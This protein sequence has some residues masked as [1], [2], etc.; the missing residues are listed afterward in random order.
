MPAQLSSYIG[1]LMWLNPRT[2]RSSYHRLHS[3]KSS[4]YQAFTPS[5]LRT[6]KS[7]YHQVSIPPLKANMPEKTVLITGC[8]TG[9]LGAAMAKAYHSR[10]FRVFATLRNKSKAGS[11]DGMQGIEILELDVTSEESVRHCAK[12]V[13]KLTGGSLDVLVNNAGIS[14]IMPLLDTSVDEAKKMY[15]SN[16]WAVI[17]MTQAFA[18]MLI[19]SKGTICNISS[20]SSELVFAWQGIYSS[21]KAAMTRISETFRL[22][23]APLGV[24]VVTVILGGV[25]TTGNNPDHRKDLELP[26]TSHY[27]S[28][29]AIIKRHAK[30]LIHDKKTN[31]DEAASNIVGDVLG[32]RVG[33]VRR[34]YASS[35][36]WMFNTFLSYALTTYLANGESGLAKLSRK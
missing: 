6:V 15:D 4:H 13:E 2:I 33:L 25:D 14:T 29:A 35:L 31:V 32:G 9:G 36:S 12:A 23:M 34:G 11:L 10:G 24:H 22:E 17:L 20:V 27:H 8:S 16:V 7:S 18:P 5:S 3:I 1:L 26:A 19:K 28:I 30:A 21:S